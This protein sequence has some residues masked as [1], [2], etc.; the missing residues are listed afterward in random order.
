M[1]LPSNIAAVLGGAWSLINQTQS[2]TFLTHTPSIL[3][4]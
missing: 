3:P 2:V 4:N 1:V